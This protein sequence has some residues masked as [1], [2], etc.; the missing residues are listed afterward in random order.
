N[1]FKAGK[2]EDFSAIVEKIRKGKI[3]ETFESSFIS[4]KWGIK[5]SQVKNNVAQTLVRDSIPATFAHIN[6]VDVSISRTDKQQPLRLVQN[7]Q[8]GFIC[9]ASTPEG[10]NSGLL[11]NLAITAKVS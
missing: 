3:T 7:S 10:E 4:N 2:Q 1:S 9:P 5:R 11:K 8:Y 6:T